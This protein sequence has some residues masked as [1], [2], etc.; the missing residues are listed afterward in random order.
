MRRS[1]CAF[2]LAG[3]LVGTASGQEPKQPAPSQEITLPKPGPK[4][5]ILKKEA[6]VWDATVETRME[7]G[8]KPV[9][10]KGVETNTLLGDGLWRVQDFKGELM[11]VPFQ[12][13]AVTGYDAAKK[14]SVGTWVDSMAPGLSSTEGSSDAK[15]GLGTPGSKGPVRWAS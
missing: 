15:A 11:G 2:G 8:G 1:L 9:V 7:L 6:G 10:T 12:G 14:K 13:H 3:L 5:E 4:H